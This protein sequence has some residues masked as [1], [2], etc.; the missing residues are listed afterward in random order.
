[1]R[2][3][4]VQYKNDYDEISDIEYA[5]EFSCS[6]LIAINKHNVRSV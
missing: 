4:I 6:Y 1:M 5:K 2:S 3:V